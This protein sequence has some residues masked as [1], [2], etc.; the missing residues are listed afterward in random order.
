MVVV[1]ILVEILKAF[2]LATQMMEKNRIRLTF[3][4][5]FDRVLTDLD[6]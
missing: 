1:E 5:H 3:S 6:W 4:L 2:A